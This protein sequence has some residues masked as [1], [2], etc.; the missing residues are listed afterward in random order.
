MANEIAVRTAYNFMSDGGTAY[1]EDNSY[2]LD[3]DSQASLPKVYGFTAIRTGCVILGFGVDTEQIEQLQQ[4]AMFKIVNRDPNNS[5][6]LL[7]QNA[8]GGSETRIIGPLQWAFF[9]VAELTVASTF[10]V[11]AS[12]ITQITASCDAASVRGELITIYKATS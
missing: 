7:I 9:N 3:A 10:T 1:N 5:M 2:N 6:T 4:S 11:A 8:A 12:R